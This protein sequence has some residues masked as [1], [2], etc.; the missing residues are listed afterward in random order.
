MRRLATTGFLWIAVFS[1]IVVFCNLGGIPLLDPDEPVYAETPKEMLLFNDWLSPRIYGDF[2]YDKPPMYYWLVTLSFK[3][4]GVNEFAARFPSALLSIICIWLVYRAGSRFFSERAGSI[5]S[6]VLAT[7][8]GYI[9]M[10]KAA[11]TDITL[12]LCFTACLLAFMEKK[13]YLF[14]LFS[15]L[16]TVTKGPIGFLFP[17]AIL[18][19]Y[20]LVTRSFSEIKQMKVPTGLLL[21]ALAGLPWYFAMY[22][23][24]GTAFTDTFLGYHNITRFTSPEHPEGVLWYYYIPVIIV[25][26][27]P[28]TAVLGQ[29][30]WTSLTDRISPN[31]RMLI[32]LNIWAAF[33]LLFFTISRTKLISYILPLF[34]PLAMLIGWYLDRL[35]TQAR[36]LGRHL[37]GWSTG[38]VLMAVLMSAV[39]FFGGREIPV[40]QPGA[41]MMIGIFAAMTALSLYFLRQ[42]A[43]FRVVLVKIASMMLFTFVLVFVLF[44]AAAP[45]FTAKHIAQRFKE[46]Y[47]G[48]SPVYVIKFLHPGFTFYTDVYGTELLRTA[49]LIPHLAQN[50]TCYVVLRKNDYRDLPAAEQQKL[51]IIAQEADKILLIKQ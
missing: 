26:F 14:Y 15:G 43:I 18:L 21:F 17:G 44:P 37:V 8:L 34:P 13:Y 39:M 45:D 29:A 41:L 36:Q 35:F 48:V 27:F 40:L 11:V 12:T 49:E 46:Q 5:G 9:Y 32:F 33:I 2:W 20:M 24:H 31:R 1:I 16:A 30:V 4:F 47:D 10:S 25:G 22:S 51:Q 3:L 6:L 50:E 38:M 28:W 19:L 23:L 42:K 7:S